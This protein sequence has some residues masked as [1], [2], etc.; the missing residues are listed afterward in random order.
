[1]R[2]PSSSSNV[3]KPPRR[4]SAK[5]GAVSESVGPVISSSSGDVRTVGVVP[6]SADVPMIGL[7]QVVGPEAPQAITPAQ[8]DDSE[9]QVDYD[10]LSSE[11]TT[12]IPDPGQDP[13]SEGHES[14]G[15]EDVEPGDESAIARLAS[16]EA[17]EEESKAND[18][19][20]LLL[21]NWDK[22]D[23]RDYKEFG[24]LYAKLS[25]GDV[26]TRDK[27]RLG[28][29]FERW[30][31]RLRGTHQMVRTWA[32]LGEFFALH[33][34]KIEETLSTQTTLSP[35]EAER[36]AF[37]HSSGL[38]SHQIM[39]AEDATGVFAWTKRPQLD[40]ASEPF[41]K[42][43]ASEDTSQIGYDEQFSSSTAQ[44]RGL[45][46]RGLQEPRDSICAQLTTICA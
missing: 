19:A 9:E 43:K 12:I 26:L 13:G 30:S 21:S 6:S 28:V 31:G 40:V 29:I 4:A 18:S 27:A 35:M 41:R 23:F 3:G 42:R 32:D 39:Y 20:F 22:K 46:V 37:L 11:G 1:M 14:P 17:L 45:A 8:R 38:Q 34:W 36:R 16:E 25:R 44:P 10:D 5:A 33:R 24:S 7:S 2:K 15:F